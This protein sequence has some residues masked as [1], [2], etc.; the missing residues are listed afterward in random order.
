MLVP[1]RKGSA[2]LVPSALVPDEHGLQRVVLV[3]V[4]LLVFVDFPPRLFFILH[5]MSLGYNLVAIQKA[6]IVFAGRSEL[7]ASSVLIG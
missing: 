3:F 1:L 5:E 4:D 7:I 6:A 2:V